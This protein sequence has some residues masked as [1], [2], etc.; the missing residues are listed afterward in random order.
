MR[1]LRVSLVWLMEVV[2][3]V[4]LDIAVMYAASYAT[5]RA[6]TKLS[7]SSRLTA[8]TRLHSLA[9]PSAFCPWEA[10]LYLRRSSRCR[11]FVH[12]GT[13]SGFW[14]G[15]EIFGWFSVF[16]FMIIS[17]FSAAAIHN[18]LIVIGGL[19][20]SGMFGWMDNAPIPWMNYVVEFQLG[21]LLLV[22]PELLRRFSR[23]LVART[24]VYGDC[25]RAGRRGDASAAARFGRSGRRLN[26]WRQ[27]GDCPS[28]STLGKWDRAF[29]RGACGVRSPVSC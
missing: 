16:L 9:S 29:I 20:A 4:A 24:C 13:V 8:H 12:A 21:T 23:R 19:V 7:T 1:H 22:L 25:E 14:L 17:S 6:R 26:R 15:F 2:A 10:C 28:G 11:E 3:I 5:P 27:V 18:Y